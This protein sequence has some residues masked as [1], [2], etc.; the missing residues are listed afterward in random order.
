MSMTIA[1]DI[2]ITLSTFAAFSERPRR[3]LAE[4]RFNFE[5]N[6]YGRRIK[7]DEVITLANGCRGIV[8]GVELYDA[9]TLDSLPH[10]RCISRCGVGIDTIDLAHAS[11]RR[12]SI[13]NTPD[14]PTIAVA[15]LTLAMMLGLLRRLPHVDSLLHDRKW[16]RLPGSLLA[17]KVV[18]II[19][20]G[21]IGRRVAE[22]V[23]AFDVTVIG[24]EPQPD[25]EWAGKN[26]VEILSL[27]D[28]LA[29]ADIVS[30]HASTTGD[31]PQLRIG[32]SELAQMKE[33]S[34]LINM[35]RGD[36]VDDNSLYDA[37]KAG[38]LAGAGLDVFPQEP[39]SG[40][41]C[42]SE[43]VILSPHQA[44]LTYETRTAM[45]CRAVDNLLRF[46]QEL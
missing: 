2:F 9:A 30:L 35:A 27:Q 46:L 3:M 26:K 4:S 16:E 40:P 5:E 43:L 15:E 12:I 20:L 8:A 33:N 41:L 6:P 31:D 10:L 14:E 36:M 13:L 21:R 42:D 34:W 37:L 11:K 22:I 44:T 39:Y 24:V 25:M 28:L 19:G 29:R 18:G 23:Q 38:R 17:G 7:P 1:S 32:S 45:E